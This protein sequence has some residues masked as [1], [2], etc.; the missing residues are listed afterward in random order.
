MSLRI[1]PDK[2]C[3]EVLP[4]EHKLMM[5]MAKKMGLKITISVLWCVVE[6]AEVA[7]CSLYFPYFLLM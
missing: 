6:S 4:G 5:F 7:C 1:M 3:S 2:V